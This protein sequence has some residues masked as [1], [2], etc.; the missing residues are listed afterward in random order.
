M[1]ARYCVLAGQISRFNSFEVKTW[2]HFC[3][4]NIVKLTEMNEIVLFVSL[5]FGTYRIC[6]KS[7][8][9][10]ICTAI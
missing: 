5:D 4:L 10:H 7:L 6:V 1:V 8:F 3:E 9:K 2:S